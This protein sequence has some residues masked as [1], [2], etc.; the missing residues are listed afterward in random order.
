MTAL[1]VWVGWIAALMNLNVKEPRK[2]S[3]PVTG[4]LSSLAE[5]SVNHKGP[6]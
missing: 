4:A 5:K 1:V 3:V 6:Q 2:K